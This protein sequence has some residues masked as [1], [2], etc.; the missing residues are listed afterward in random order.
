[1]DVHESEG[2]LV[3]TLRGGI[4]A[5]HVGELLTASVQVCDSGKP[6]A[7]D[8]SEAEHLHAGALQ[9]LLALQTELQSQGRPLLVSDCSLALED[10]LEAAGLLPTFQPAR[11]PQ[12][13]SIV[14]GTDRG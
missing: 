7:L 5:S 14:Y 8:W 9:V 2:R 4:D 6:V 10:C 3:M 1:M 11:V 12:E 13:K